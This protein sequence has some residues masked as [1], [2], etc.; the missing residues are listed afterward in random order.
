MTRRGLTLVEVL[1]AAALLAVTVGALVPLLRDARDVG[2]LDESAIAIF[3][4]AQ[5]AD[6]LMLELT[7]EDARSLVSVPRHERAVGELEKLPIRV[8]AEIRVRDDESHAW[9]VFER[10]G[11]AV[12]RWIQLPERRP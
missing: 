10:D 7:A 8:S 11:L 1:A 9:I 12:T 6:R 2:E 4:L 3:E 5:A